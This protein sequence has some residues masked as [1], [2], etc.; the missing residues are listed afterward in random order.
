MKIENKIKISLAV[1]LSSL[2]VVGIGISL[3]ENDKNGKSN[4]TI[5]LAES[6]SETTN[7]S[8][9]TDISSRQTSSKK[10]YSSKNKSIKTEDS[11][12]EIGSEA[13]LILNIV[14]DYSGSPYVVV[15]DNI[16]YFTENELTAKAYEE[17]SKLDYLGRTGTAIASLGVETMPTENEKRKSISNIKPTG[18]I[19]SKYD[20]ISGKYLY[21][22][23]HLI[24]W[25]LSAENDNERNLITGTKYLNINGMLPFENMVADY[26]KETLNHVAYRVTPLY[27]DNDFLLASG[28]QIE[29]YS[30][31]DKGEGICFNVFCYNVQ[32]NI[33]IDY[34]TGAS[35]EKII[36]QNESKI[37]NSSDVSVK[38][39]STV[40]TGNSNMVWISDSGSKY[41]SRAGCSNMK[42]PQ[43]IDRSEAE[44]LGYGQCKR[45]W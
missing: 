32:P 27:D 28:V 35:K 3:S 25:Q 4:D 40:S 14:P 8:A 29:A 24:G 42:K 36:S 13:P 45:C 2:V 17:Y 7:S 12:D 10:T 21:N 43:Q 6:F 38:E 9:K 19:Q 33:E 44:E 26:I 16:P 41:H 18:W 11:E 30:I 23:C 15:N 34:K 22:R 1:L 31:E 37:T 5:S 39:S 20:S